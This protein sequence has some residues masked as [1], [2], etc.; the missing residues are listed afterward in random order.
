ML[1]ARVLALG[2]LLWLWISV[3]IS[4]GSCGKRPQA[5]HRLSTGAFAELGV[6]LVGGEDG[7]A[8]VRVGLSVGMGV[9]RPALFLCLVWGYFRHVLEGE[10]CTFP[11]ALLL[12][13][14]DRV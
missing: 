14:H 4:R 7:G 6:W 12:L 10:L 1:P 5:V 13:D 11:Q 9:W 2:V 3:W 8:C